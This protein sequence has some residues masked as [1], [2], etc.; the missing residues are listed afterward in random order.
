MSNSVYKHAVIVLYGT[1]KITIHIKMCSCKPIANEHNEDSTM[2]VFNS[3][4][5]NSSLFNVFCSYLDHSIRYELIFWSNILLSKNLNWTDDLA[6]GQVVRK[7][8]HWDAILTHQGVF[9]SSEFSIGVT[10]GDVECCFYCFFP[11]V[12]LFA[13]KHIR[14]KYVQIKT[15]AFLLEL[16][17]IFSYI[18]LTDL[19]VAKG[20]D[21]RIGVFFLE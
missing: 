6:D 2:Y 13:G 3:I 19:P 21:L 8:A 18:R 12:I 10:Y 1:G 5:R 11:N 7:S 20:Q 16:C 14:T 17:I 9:Q 4:W 15:I